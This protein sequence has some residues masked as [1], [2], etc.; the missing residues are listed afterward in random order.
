MRI[1]LLA[2]AP[3]IVGAAVFLSTTATTT[4]TAQGVCGS[5]KAALEY[6][7][8]QYRERPRALGLAANN[9]VV[10]LLVSETG[11]WTILVSYPSGTSCV[12]ASGEA[13]ANLPELA[14]PP[15]EPSS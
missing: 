14:E 6:L 11:S 5:R 8:R 1:V 7:E 4:A 10:E 2:A 9:N 3:I 12:V 15:E 13:W